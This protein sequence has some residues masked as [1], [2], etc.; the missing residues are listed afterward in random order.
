MASW[1]LL[2]LT[3]C[4]VTANEKTL[5][6]VH[7]VEIRGQVRN[8][9]DRYKLLLQHGHVQD[10]IALVSKLIDGDE[11]GV[12]RVDDSRYASLR[13][14]CHHLIAQLPPESLAK[15]RRLADPIAESWYAEGIANRDER[16]L[17][18]VVD[19][20]FC[21]RWGDDALLALGELALDRADY[22]QAR[23]AWLRLSPALWPPMGQSPH[24]NKISWLTYP[25]TDLD[26]AKVRAWLALVSIRE[27]EFNKAQA[28]I[29]RLR[30]LHPTARGS[31][32]GKDSIYFQR[33]TELLNQASREPSRIDE[34]E[35]SHGGKLQQRWAMKWEY[36]LASSAALLDTT[37][38]NQISFPIA[39][40]NTL[41]YADA[42]RV[43]AVS[44]AT[45]QP[46]YG[47]QSAIYSFAPSDRPNRAVP[48]RNTSSEISLT[49]YFS[50]A[51]TRVF[52]VAL[53]P[54]NRAFENRAFQSLAAKPESDEAR[55]PL[56]GLDLKREGAL[57]FR[58][59]PDDGRWTFAG[60]PKV[61]DSLT[62]D[63]PTGDGLTGDGQ[64]LVAMLE[65]DV[66][67]RV[68]IACYHIGSQ[69]LLWRR[70]ICEVDV[71]AGGEQAVQLP[72]QLMLDEGIVYCNT[73]R[74][75]VAALRA[76]DGHVLWIRTYSRTSSTRKNPRETTGER[77]L[78]LFYHGLL[79]LAPADRGEIIAIDAAGGAL[80]WSR[81]V[82]EVGARILGATGGK[83]VLSR[84]RL[85]AL[86]VATGE[87]V[88]EWGDETV[89]GETADGAG[90]GGLAGQTVYWPA[91][92]D[93]LA[94]DSSTGKI[95]GKQPDLLEPGGVNLVVA[96]EYLV[97]TGT[98]KIT[99]FQL[100]ASPA[101]QTEDNGK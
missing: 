74:G 37:N 96:G 39:V 25:E 36:P 100:A 88:P 62:G 40:G 59:M 71:P 17:R 51:G 81:P 23:N 42:N 32:G 27:G 64:V 52:V 29:D 65:R 72:I 97:A 61:D 22:Q 18:R 86:D 58:R 85:W 92:R 99:V 91:Q 68:W 44:L 67:S 101:N 2:L 33:L 5:P 31:L 95:V 15:Y 21:S 57:F 84:K 45:G 87:R 66:R 56:V 19:R 8:E 34:T 20:A 3:C 43:H 16:L 53:S 98:S 4:D 35:Q 63:G 76:T 38:T 82:P 47:Q 9:L 93:L 80:A 26:L 54:E 75:A 13:D 28:E 48:K 78:G 12:V 77:G 69:K 89:D 60:V 83:L 94:I 70:A 14:Y 90:Q 73:N 46:A 7:V 24:G 79:L 41:L 30:K 6:P 49:L 1:L 55:L 11:P 50:A 10:A